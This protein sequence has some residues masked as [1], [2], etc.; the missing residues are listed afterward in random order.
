MVKPG[1]ATFQPRR[2]QWIFRHLLSPDATPALSI[3]LTST[4]QT[5]QFSRRRQRVFVAVVRILPGSLAHRCVRILTVYWSQTRNGIFLHIIL[6]VTK[7]IFQI[8][9]QG[10]SLHYNIV[11]WGN[12][13]IDIGICS[14]QRSA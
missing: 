7:R 8:L 1:E 9:L 10:F 13:E 4:S 2:W 11:H 6:S 12:Y 3:E 14:S 5:R